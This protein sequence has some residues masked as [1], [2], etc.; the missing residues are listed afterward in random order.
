MSYYAE[1]CPDLAQTVEFVVNELAG[2][3]AD[4]SLA[5]YALAQVFG[6]GRAGSGYEERGEAMA[7]DL[8]DGITPELVRKFRAAVL[9][10]RSSPELYAELRSRMGSTYGK[11][12]PGYGQGVDRA[13]DDFISYIIGPPQQFES[14]EAYIRRV[15][16]AAPL[17]RLYPRDY[18]MTTSETGGQLN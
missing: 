6:T 15:A 12:L 11:V 16:G 5:E 14:Y 8:E 4:S 17:F 18:W 7:A 10:L 13:G 1:R 3:P 2:A 9:D